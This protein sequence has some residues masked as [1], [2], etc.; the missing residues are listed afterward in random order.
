MWD[1][2]GRPYLQIG[3]VSAGTCALRLASRAAASLIVSLEYA[4]AHTYSSVLQ[5]ILTHVH[6]VREGRGRC[7]AEGCSPSPPRPHHITLF[8]YAAVT[9]LQVVTPVTITRAYVRCGCRPMMLIT[10]PPAVL[11]TYHASAYASKQYSTTAL[12]LRF[13]APAHAWLLTYQVRHEP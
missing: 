4:S 6:T 9:A 12:W 3:E 10:I 1:C 7:E 13:G 8:R 5:Y 2:S 11:A